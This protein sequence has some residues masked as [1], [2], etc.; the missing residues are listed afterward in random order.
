VK[1]QAIIGVRSEKESQPTKKTRR[2]GR[3]YYRLSNEIEK[4]NGKERKKVIRDF[5]EVTELRKKA[6]AEGELGGVGVMS[7]GP[8]MGKKLRPL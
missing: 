5:W 3:G 1:R 7:L 8:G 6:N 4:Q 2:K